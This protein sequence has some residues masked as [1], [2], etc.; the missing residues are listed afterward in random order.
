[1]IEFSFFSTPMSCG[2]VNF[3]NILLICFLVFLGD[4][5]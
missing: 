2:I 5:Y 1:M 3:M 4:E